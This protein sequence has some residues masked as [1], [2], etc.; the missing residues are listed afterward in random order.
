[1]V[2]TTARFD[3]GFSSAV[4]EKRY[5]DRTLRPW[6]PMYDSAFKQQRSSLYNGSVKSNYLP[7][8]QGQLVRNKSDFYL[9]TSG[10]DV[11]NNYHNNVIANRKINKNSSG[12]ESPDVV[13]YTKK[14]R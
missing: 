7:P 13:D 11:N 1:M 3:R 9:N 2:L 4:S 5:S 8:Y 6:P 12:F 14:L 10:Y